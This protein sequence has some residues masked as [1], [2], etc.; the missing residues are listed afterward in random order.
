VAAVSVLVPVRDRT[1]HLANLVAGL[2]RADGAP[3]FELLVGWMGGED[4]R[5]ALRR[6]LGFE[7]RAVEIEGDEMPLAR[8]R[9]ELAKAASGSVVVFLD[10]DCVP[11][12]GLLDSYAR[13]LREHDALAIGETR[14]LPRGFRADGADER[15]LRRAARAHPER[16][17]L[18]PGPGE[19]RSGGAHELFWSL[20][21]AVRRETFRER[22]GGFDEAY[23]GY[24]IED[25]DFAMRAARAGVPLAWVGGALAFHQHHPPTRLRP[26]GVPALVE[27]VRRYR[28]R[29]GEW[30]AKGWLE[31]LAAT[32]LIDW[33]E[34][35]GTLSPRPS[36]AKAIR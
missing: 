31:E 34:E 22:I 1:E 17:G 33:D 3:S 35:A 14:Y 20:S 9:N 21:F 2:G 11:S 8:A 19:V 29:W 25:T 10:V 30:P 23:R 4:P 13:A 26:E 7:A 15:S 24:G 32:G 16:G 28:E 27:N 6:A 36:R 18:F 5:P 12:S